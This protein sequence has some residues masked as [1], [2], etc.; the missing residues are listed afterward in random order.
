MGPCGLVEAT[1]TRLEAWGRYLTCA[2]LIALVSIVPLGPLFAMDF[3]VIGN[4]LIASGPV[5][6]NEFD[7]LIGLLTNYPQIDTIILRNSPGG[8]AP[9]GYRVGALI[10]EKGLRT[11]VP[12]YCYSSCSRMFLG[13]RSRHFTNDYLPEY[14]DVAFTVTTART[15]SY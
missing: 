14:T 13:G 4:Q 10:R 7:V 2:L 1:G 8:D 5:S 15:G 11:A 3:V 6:G 12:G 9:T